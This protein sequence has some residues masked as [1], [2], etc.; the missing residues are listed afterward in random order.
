MLELEYVDTVESDTAN[1]MKKVAVFRGAYMRIADATFGLRTVDVTQ[2][3]SK[4]EE[5]FADVL[6]G[7][8]VIRRGK[9]TIEPADDKHYRFSFELAE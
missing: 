1:G 8:N 9:L 6:V 3:N 2:F 7:M 4:E 5:P